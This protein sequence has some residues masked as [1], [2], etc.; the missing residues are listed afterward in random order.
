M[1]DSVKASPAGL[2]RIDQARRRKGW[3][4]TAEAWCSNAFTSR[5]TL[6]RFWARRAIRRETFMTI[7][8]AVGLDW[9]EVI[10]EEGKSWSVDGDSESRLKKENCSSEDWGQA[11]DVS[12][13]C[14]R[15]EELNTLRQWIVVERCRLVSILGMGGIGKTS[16]A[17]KFAQQQPFKFVIWR[18]LRNAPQPED[19]LLELVGFFCAGQEDLPGH[20]D[21][22]M[23]RLLH[24][25]RSAPC[26]LILDNVESILQSGNQSKVAAARRAYREGYERYGQLIC[27]LG[28]TPHSSTLILT[29]REPLPG[30]AALEGQ[31]LPGRCLQLKGLPQAEGREVLSAGL[32][33]SENDWHTLIERYGGN[34]LALKIVSSFV[35]DFFDGSVAQ[36]LFL[37][38]EPFV[39]EDICNLLS[40]QF[41]RLSTLEQQIIY[42]LAINRE[43]VTYQELRAD[44]VRSLP[45]GEIVQGLMSVQRRSLVEKTDAGFTLQPVVMEYAIAQLSEQVALEM[46]SGDLNLLHSHALLKA[47]AKD[48][49]RKAQECLILQP[50]ID[51]LKET[52][53][54]ISAV[55]ARCRE[56]LNKLR[57]HPPQVGYAGGNIFNV[58]RQMQVELDGYDFSHLALWQANCRGINLHRV[59]F[60]YSDLSKSVFTQTFGS[61]LTVAFSPDGQTLATGDGN[62]DIQIWQVASGQPHLTLPGHRNWVQS[63]VFSPNGI[64]ASGSDDETIRL[65]DVQSG[66]L[67]H[68][69]SGHTNSVRSLAF[70]PDGERLASSSTDGTIRLWQ[71]ATGKLVKVFS[72]HHS[73]V[74]SVAY[75]PDGQLLASG[76]SDGTV[77]LWNI[78]TG[79]SHTLKGHASWVWSVAFSP[80][81]TLLASGSDDCTIKLWNVRSNQVETLTGHTN[82]VRSVAF[83]ANDGTLISGSDDRTIRL[84]NVTAGRSKTLSGHSNSV[85]SAACSPDGKMLASG[86]T[87]QTVRLWDVATGQAVRTLQGH[88]NWV[89]SVSFSPDGQILAS[90]SDDSTIKLWDITRETV[91]TLSGHTNWVWSAVFSPDGQIIASAS[92]DRTVRLWNVQSGQTITTLVGHIDWVL[93]IAFSPDGTLIA[94]AS[95]DRTVKLWDIAGQLRQTL[96]G[97]ADWVRGVAFS[98]DGRSLASAS[99][100]GTVRLWDV[101]SGKHQVLRGHTDWVLCVAF[102]PDGLTLASGSTDC[103]IKLW[104]LTGENVSTL[105]GHANSVQSVAYSKNGYLAS[106]SK[107]ETIKLWHDETCLKTL[108]GNQP[109]QGTNIIGVTGLSE[110][111]LATLQALGAVC[112]RG[113]ELTK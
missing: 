88:T 5:A 70:S 106:C 108:K 60:A 6:N 83:H 93:C 47:Q 74:W 63:V 104:T 57:A 15:E 55:K 61:I 31:S 11:P 18:S 13:F 102:S 56:I 7:C 97:H 32:S 16:L 33:A 71:V 78:K 2:E 103:T 110:A 98:P 91:R 9:E 62:G 38:Q 112:W 65:W 1:A 66:Q 35:R 84:W 27:C 58:L 113:D 96:T 36:F 20:F 68:S 19:L 101:H 111:Q 64:L 82:A 22:K 14:G 30:L 105:R 95:A 21:G 41:Y 53:G 80:D 72:G 50:L 24:Y 67:L 107:D 86:S 40:Q 75:S 46:A 94:S 76:S 23:L 87:D 92:D 43:S 29:S 99:T 81:G 44:F 26:L 109:Y 85:W 90:G 69:L 8:Q 42:W 37:L 54:S 48:Y 49:V 17:I 73:S 77:K 12:S 10:E 52:F 100:D 34:P 3:N 4:K 89:F 28:E 59:T 25:L 45:C 79:R 51:R 39:F